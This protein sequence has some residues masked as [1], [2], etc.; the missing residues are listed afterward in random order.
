MAYPR[1]SKSALLAL[2]TAG[3]LW[4]WQNRSKL[5]G[6][7]QQMQNNR[8][9]EPLMSSGTTTTNTPLTSDPYTDATQRLGSDDLGRGGH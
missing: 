6:M 2:A 9:S 4:A 8:R 1:N 5:A 7:W 3:G